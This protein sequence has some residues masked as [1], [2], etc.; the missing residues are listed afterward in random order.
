MSDQF[1][2]PSPPSLPPVA[3]SGYQPQSSTPTTVLVLGI[4]SIVLAGLPPVGLILGIVGLNKAKG[5]VQD[6]IAGRIHP[7]QSGM[8]T[9]GKICSI[10][11]ICVGGLSTLFW[12]VY[13][14]CFGSMLF[15]AITHPHRP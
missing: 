11:G 2:P 12:C 4:L 6:L 8:V 13:A 10:V 1:P 9:A 15:H 5:A 14:S 3:L 7:S